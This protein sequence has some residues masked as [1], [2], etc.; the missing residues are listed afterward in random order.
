AGAA[1]PP[2]ENPVLQHPICGLDSPMQPHALRAAPPASGRRVGFGHIR[3]PPFAQSSCRIRPPL[4]GPSPRTRP[5]PRTLVNVRAKWTPA[6]NGQLG[7]PP[8]HAPTCARVG[9][10]QSL[11]FARRPPLASGSAPSTIARLL[12]I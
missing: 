2:E 6:Q 5:S 12:G 9:S 1:L 10:L 8:S 3:R 7:Q 4:S 11:R